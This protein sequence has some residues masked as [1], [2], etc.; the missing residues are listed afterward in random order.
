VWCMIVSSRGYTH[1]RVVEDGGG[2]CSSRGVVHDC[3]QQ[4]LVQL[5]LVKTAQHEQDVGADALG[6]MFS[7]KEGGRTVRTGMTSHAIA[8]GTLKG[9]LSCFKSQ[10][11]GAKKGAS[12]LRWLP[13]YQKIFY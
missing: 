13:L 8:K 2:G 11:T 1:L 7:L 3:L 12:V 4:G 9:L 5:R 10:K 6:K